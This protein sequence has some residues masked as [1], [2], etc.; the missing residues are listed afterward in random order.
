MTD[1]FYCK[2]FVATDKP[3]EEV[4]RLVSMQVSEIFEDIE[5]DADVSRN[6]NFLS[7]W[8]QVEAFD[9]IENCQFF[10]DLALVE[11]YVKLTDQF[12]SNAAELV[13]GIRKSIGIA[14]ASCEFEDKIVDFCGW[15][16][17]V[18]NPNPPGSTLQRGV[19]A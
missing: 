13:C 6:D 4:R 18:N 3:I 8:G 12:H 5:V 2:I 16:W 14:V 10:V 19:S 1:P 9:F 15:N 11:E 7:E 17:T